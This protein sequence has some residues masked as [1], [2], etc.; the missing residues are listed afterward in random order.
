MKKKIIFC[1]I[2]ILL[3]SSLLITNV[4]IGRLN[5]HLR[6]D[7]IWLASYMLP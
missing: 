1:M 4:L 2:L 5:W 6:A 7:F 3:G